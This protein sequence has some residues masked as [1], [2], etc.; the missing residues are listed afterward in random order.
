MYQPVLRLVSD[1]YD[2]IAVFRIIKPARDDAPIYAEFYIKPLLCLCVFGKLK[3]EHLE[4]MRML[5][6]QIINMIA[7]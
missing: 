4:A 1:R 2:S 6:E 3:C 7:Y 5:V